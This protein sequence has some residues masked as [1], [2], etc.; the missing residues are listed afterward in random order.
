MHHKRIRLQL[1]DFVSGT[2]SEQERIVVQQHVDAC[3]TCRQELQSLERTLTVLGRSPGEPGSA[4]SE[5]FWME[6]ADSVERSIG[7]V[8]H[9]R[10]WS[11]RDA[12]ESIGLMVR[13]HRGYAYAL[14][15]GVAAV[16]GA[17][18]VIPR[19]NPPSLPAVPESISSVGVATAET[20]TDARMSEFFR[21]SRTLLVEIA[22]M[23]EDRIASADLGAE[24]QFS[25][26]LIAQTRSLRQEH[27]GPHAKRLVN[28]L[29]KILI[30]FANLEPA[31]GRSDVELI[32]NGIAQEN[33]LFKLRMAEAMFDTAAARFVNDTY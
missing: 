7:T 23:R 10:R 1:Y 30:E 4:R 3:A 18:L 24:Q 25:Q 20:D 5:E 28:D 16:L 22:N 11:L 13:A 15:A 31:A 27:L 12:L 17:L 19:E 26:E 32:R 9:P 33:L 21:R 6:L 14:G 29:E 8:P 2:L